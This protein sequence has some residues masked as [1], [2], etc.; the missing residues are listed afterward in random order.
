MSV[1]TPRLATGLVK[2]CHRIV[3]KIIYGSSASW[4]R[5]PRVVG[6]RLAGGTGHSCLHRQDG[7]SFPRRGRLLCKKFTHSACSCG[8]GGRPST[9]LESGFDKGRM[10]RSVGWSPTAFVSGAAS[11]A[12]GPGPRSLFAMASACC[13]MMLCSRSITLVDVGR[14]E[15]VQELHLL[16]GGMVEIEAAARHRQAQGIVH[17]RAAQRQIELAGDVEAC[18]RAPPPPPCGAAPCARDIGCRGRWPALAASGGNP[19]GRRCW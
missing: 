17:V 4:I 13:G 6:N 1:V 12:I 19:C 5:F 16:L 14:V 7:A 11:A 9:L 2:E 15:Q 18:C 3:T 10:G 8:V